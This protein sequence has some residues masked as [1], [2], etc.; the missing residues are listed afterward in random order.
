MRPRK[1]RAPQVRLDASGDVQFTKRLC[2]RHKD[3]AVDA[4][5]GEELP[6]GWHA[7]VG[8]L[9]DQIATVMVGPVG[10]I[11]V[12]RLGD[13]AGGLAADL[14]PLG[15]T[16]EA[17]RAFET[18]QGLVERAR[19]A[20]ERTCAACGRPGR[21]RSAGARHAARCD[22]HA[23]EFAKRSAPTELAATAQAAAAPDHRLY[24]PSDVEA[25]LGRWSARPASGEGW[26]GD[27]D[28]AHD[29]ASD[30]EHQRR[31]R[32]LVRRGQE[33]CRRVLA[34]PD[35]ASLRALADLAERAPHMAEVTSFVRRHLLAAIAMGTPTALPAVMLL[36]APGTGKTWFLSR[37]AALLGVPFRR[38]N[39]SG[40]S[41]ADGLAGAYPTWRN[42]QPGVVAKCLLDEHVANP[43]VLV[44]E[45]DKAGNHH[46]EDPYR[47]LYD[48][49]EPEG[50]RTFTDEYL[51]FPMDASR[52]L[53]ALA[54]NDLAP[55]PAP[56]ADRLTV[57][58]V[59]TPDEA[60]MRAVAVSVYRE[61]NAD[62]R[63]FFEP[64]LGQA[65]VARLLAT[66]PRGLRKAI[67]E[68]MAS[69]AADG[70]RALRPDD[71]VIPDPP[72][73]LFGFR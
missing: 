21:V 46:M 11:N 56:I 18:V 6:E 44:D 3:W 71:V 68:A 52:V 48:L 49:L 13:E 41:I 35:P 67:A 51:G 36:G 20:S 1:V 29:P 73:R 45:V 9:F 12:H 42:A 50:A 27:P 34:L 31:L 53:W 7:L 17:A 55:L 58:A 69:A 15:V 39:M 5:E 38:H 60:Q 2:G 64:D 8:E 62:R 61:C 37:L 65:V 19:R 24:E 23:G 43:L 25:A 26:V 70:R 40:Q 16:V 57:L 47:A 59:P 33:G 72:R 54:G 22:A 66:N 30:S 4:T 10:M 32:D 63:D 14:R 28:D